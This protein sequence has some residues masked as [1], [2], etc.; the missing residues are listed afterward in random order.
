MTLCRHRAEIGP[1]QVRNG[2]YHDETASR[3]ESIVNWMETNQEMNT[4]RAVCF[5]VQDAQYAI[6]VKA[7]TYLK[8]I[9]HGCNILHES[10]NS[11]V[12]CT[13]DINRALPVRRA[14]LESA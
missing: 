3:T 7:R 5:R 8:P 12:K 1:E 6:N 2:V 11:Q 4:K 13:M 9:K 10:N 14:I